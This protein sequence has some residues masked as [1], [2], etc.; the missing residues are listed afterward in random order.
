VQGDLY[1]EDE[2]TDN[3]TFLLKTAPFDARFSQ[4]NVRGRCRN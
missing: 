3:R 1:E 4:T 2:G